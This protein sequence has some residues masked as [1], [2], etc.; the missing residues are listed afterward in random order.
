MI[1]LP[2]F[3]SEPLAY[4]LEDWCLPLLCRGTHTIRGGF[5]RKGD[6]ALRSETRVAS[7]RR[8]SSETRSSVTKTLFAR[9]TDDEGRVG[10]RARRGTSES[11]ASRAFERSFASRDASVSH[12]ARARGRATPRR[13]ARSKRDGPPRGTNE[14]RRLIR[15]RGARKG[16]ARAYPVDGCVPGHGVLVVS[17]D[18]RHGADSGGVRRARGSAARRTA[19]VN[20][21]SAQPTE[22]C[23]IFVGRAFSPLSDN[24]FTT[25]ILL[26][27][28]FT[29][30]T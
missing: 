5:T 10:T 1:T 30:G 4:A 14:A 17:V 7:R 25:R 20:S 16:N 9:S 2:Q 27:L 8:R 21:S 13:V 29:P 12:R 28:L 11:S 15:G 3:W 24:T 26:L 19:K 18:E 23:R 22:T 6:D